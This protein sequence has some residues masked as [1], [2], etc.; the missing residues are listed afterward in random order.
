MTGMPPRRI[1]RSIVLDAIS[2][3]R[4]ME[5][6]EIAEETARIIDAHRRLHDR[7]ADDAPPLD[8]EARDALALACLH[9]RIWRESYV[10]SWAH[11]NEKAIILQARQ[12]VQRIDRTERALGFRYRLASECLEGC[13]MVSI[14][15]LRSRP[16]CAD[17]EIPMGKENA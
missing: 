9:A 10:D 13:E 6:P 8:D 11:T 2:D 7:L 15:E 4:A 14:D 12:A 16:R 1:L 3:R 5:D 17:P